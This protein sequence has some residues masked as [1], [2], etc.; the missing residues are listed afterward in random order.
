MSELTIA[1]YDWVPDGPRGFVRDLRLRWACEEAGLKYAVHSVPFEGRETN[2]LAQQPF[3]QV[4]FLKD[5]LA[6]GDAAVVAAGKATADLL[7]EAVDGDPRVQVLERGEV[8]RARTP[9]AITTFRRLAEQF[10]ETFPQLQDALTVVV[11]G[12]TPELAE[13]AA[14][15]LT[16]AMA[17]DSGLALA[18]RTTVGFSANVMT[19]RLPSPSVFSM[20]ST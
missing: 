20:S 19:W 16:L 13:D 17:A 7:R 6:A 4:P 5:G 18:L 15:R 8:Y 2:H 9:A 1:T 11:D 10:F 12:A 14:T 3:G